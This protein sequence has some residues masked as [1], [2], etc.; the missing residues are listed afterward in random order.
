[1]KWIA[2]TPGDPA[3]IGPEVVWKT[4]SSPTFRGLR[5]R[6]V[7]IGAEAPFQRW[8]LPLATLDPSLLK[9]PPRRTRVTARTPVWILPAPTAAPREG[10]HLGGYQ[11]GWSIETAARLALQGSVAAIV[12]GPISKDHLQKGGFAFPGHTEMFAQ[13]AGNVPVTMMLANDRLRVTLVTTHVALGD[14]P[15][16]L[17]PQ[18]L[19]R[20]LE[21]TYQHLTH[22]VGLRKPRIAVCGLNPHAGE[23]GLFGLEESQVIEPVCREL[24]NHWGNRVALEGPLPADTLFA[25]HFSARPQDRWDAVVCMY[26]DQ[27]LIPVKLIDFAHTV[28]VTL[29]LP[30]LRTSVDHGTAFD[31]AGRGKAD[32]SSFQS[33]LKMAI[34]SV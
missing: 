19:K 13:L 27:G 23:G 17:T 33:A 7:L 8:K 31:I 34:N 20:A 6:V 1:M 14:V 28:N 12:T 32:P 18:G 10:A 16:A 26:H 2:I 29:G 11:S 4:L 25:R 30:F 21:Q 9:K 5:S 24:R 15:R 3:G 22:Q